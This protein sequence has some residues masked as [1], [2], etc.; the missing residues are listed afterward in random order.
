[1]GT[2][3]G[4]HVG[5]RGP[6]LDGQIV[7]ALAEIFD[8]LL[9][10]AALA[11][12]LRTGKDEIGGGNAFLEPAL[13][14]EADHLGD[15]HRDRLAEHGRLRLDAAHTPAEHA[16]GIDHGGVAI[17]TDTGVG[18]RLLGPP[19][20]GPHALGQ[21]FEV[22]LMANAGARRHHAEVVEGAGA[23]AQELVAF[24]VALIFDLDVPGKSIGRA[25]EINL[26]R[27]VDDQVDGH[28]GIDLGG[29]AAECLH[30]IAHG[31]EIDNG[32][33]AGEVLHQHA[34]RS[35]GDLHVRALALQ[36]VEYRANILRPDGTTIFVPQQVLD[37]HLEGERQS[38][39]PVEPILLGVGKRKVLVR[40]GADL[41]GLA[42]LE[43]VKRGAAHARASPMY[44]ARTVES[45]YST[46]PGGKPGPYIN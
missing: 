19:G 46:W 24:L 39:K 14:A 17:G 23:P 32:G 30:G 3:L 11:Q 45:A 36:P 15:H 43:A 38:R 7:E 29:I 41:E 9:D 4:R 44:G 21:I 33:N 6:I 10:H 12:H 28:Q 18:K 1:S 37:Q 25:K 35:I 5:D 20:L 2:V 42:A 13:E 8:E 16:Q 26:H 22:D 31:G 27:V 40:L 34:R